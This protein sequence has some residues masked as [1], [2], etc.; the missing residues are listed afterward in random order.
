[1]TLIDTHAHL[2]SERFDDDRNGMVQRALATGVERMYLPNVDSQ[3]IQGMLA[4]EEAFPQH[5]FA[6]MG[7]HPCSVDANYKKELA[8]AEKWLADR[9]FCAVGEIGIDLYWDKTHISEQKSAFITQIHWARELNIPFIIHS[10]ESI[11]EI[12]K[13][14]DAEQDGNLRGIFHCFSGT[15]EQAYII[16]QLG[17]LMGIGGVLTY[18]KADLPE[19]VKQVP[20]TALVLETDAPYL[21]PTPHRGKR[22]ESAYLTLIAEKLAEAKQT[23]IEEVA[24]VTTANALQLFGD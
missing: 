11:D 2:Y 19:V 13:I 7:L 10:R 6:M 21:P 4:L 12:I 1:M 18:K 22:N 14:V 16:Q 15:V 3:S 5:C 9:P 17:F 8:I 24:A 20:L 23:T